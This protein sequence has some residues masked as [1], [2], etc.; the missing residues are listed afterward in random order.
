[1]AT[2]RQ[3]LKAGVFAGAAVAVGGPVLLTRTASAAADIIDPTTIP[4]YVT[5]LFVLPQMPKQDGHKHTVA[6]RRINAQVL[7]SG[8]PSTTVCAFGAPSVPSSFHS[9]AYTIEADV[10]EATQVTWVNQQ[11][12]N[13]G[14]FLPPLLTVDPTLHWANPPGG[15]DGRDTMPS[16]T[17]TPP[18]YTGPVPLVVHLHG[19]HVTQ[20]SDGFPEAWYLPAAKNIPS[21][22]A[23]SGS[24]YEQFREEAQ[25]LYGLSWAPGSLTSVYPNDQ[26]ATTL[27]YH[28]HSLGMT[29]TGVHSGLAGMYLLRGGPH[30]TPPGVLPGPAPRLGDPPGT[31]YYEIPLV[32]T[33]RS[34]NTDGSIFFP[35]SRTEFGDT[36]GPFIPETDIPPYWNPVWQG[37]TTTV[38]GNTWPFLEVEPRRYRFRVLNASNIRPYS[39]MVVSDPLPRPATSAL[40]IWV[41]GSDGGFLPQ[42]QANTTGLPIFT[43]ER[44]D[45]VVDFSGLSEG[46]ELYLINTF[47]NAV[48]GTTGQLVKFRVTPLTSP[49]T[50]VPMDQLTLPSRTPLG[51]VDN[52]RKVSASQLQSTFQPSVPAEFRLGT[53]NPDGTAHPMD[54]S[55]PVTETPALNSTEI[56]EIHNFA[57]GGHAI[58]IHLVEFE[59]LDRQPLAGGTPTPA[60]PWETGTKDTVFS[61]GRQITRVKSHFDLRSRYPWHCHFIDHEDHGMMR[62]FQVI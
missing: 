42:P 13:K 32:L 54:W 17:S 34:F 20:E 37:N 11:A 47:G 3:F 16:F 30:D 12:D 35:S 50:T 21:G 48:P 52:T 28:D 41:I 18:P 25:D 56:W 29:R 1:M 55:E 27:W 51:A 39:L 45:I 4:K 58:H 7:P 36:N 15:E 10:D 2:R 19:A 38:N 23:T 57:A 33:D 22:Y 6:S 31:K 60:S 46:T 24:F 40:P 44:Y 59:V 62:P 5:P 53:V 8:F 26:R 14:N 49:D 43:S 61:P 9:P